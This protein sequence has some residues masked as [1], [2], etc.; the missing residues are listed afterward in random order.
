ME[1]GRDKFHA[2]R[3][4]G[5]GFFELHDQLRSSL[6]NMEEL[7]MTRPTRKV[8]SSKG[9]SAGP[10]ITAFHVITL[11]AIGEADTPTGGSVCILWFGC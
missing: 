2:W 7:S 5:I 1:H 10:M 11:S 3:F 9:V 4:V 6:A 8:P